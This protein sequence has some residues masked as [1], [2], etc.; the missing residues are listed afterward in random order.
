MKERVRSLLF[1]YPLSELGFMRFW[2]FWIISLVGF[3]HY[4]IFQSYNPKIRIQTTYDIVKANR[5]EIRVETSEGEGAEF[6]IQIPV[7]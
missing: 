7:V 1:N 4:L 2:D 3:D 6:I 5:R